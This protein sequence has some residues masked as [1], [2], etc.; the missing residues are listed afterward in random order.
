MWTFVINIKINESVIKMNNYD[1]LLNDFEN[2]T[3]E[4]RLMN[5]LDYS[6][7]S[8]N[9]QEFKDLINNI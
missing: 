3:Y 1:E 7:Q 2:D 8:F 4:K 6:N 5:R 9:N